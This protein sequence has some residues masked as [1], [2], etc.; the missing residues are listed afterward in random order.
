MHPCCWP[1]MIQSF[2]QAVPFLAVFA[3]AFK[4]VWDLMP[5][6]AKAQPTNEA[7]ASCCSQK[8]AASLPH[9]STDQ[10]SEIKITEIR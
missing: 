3:L 4:K 9:S 10:A 1:A 7:M 8:V 5:K 2:L 6:Q